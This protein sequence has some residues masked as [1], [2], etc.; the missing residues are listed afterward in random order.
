MREYWNTLTTL[1]KIKFSLSIIL[2]I[3][4]ILFAFQNWEAENVNMLF[5]DIHIPLT[6]LIAISMF[7]GFSI[8]AFLNYRELVSKEKE[9]KS[10]KKKLK[11]LDEKK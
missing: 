6:L 10:L 1:K 3:L 8:S 5:F 7:I 4:I 9:I 2:F 11:E